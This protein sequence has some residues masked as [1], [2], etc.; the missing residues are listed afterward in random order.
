MSGPEGVCSRGCLVLGGSGPGGL[1]P[2]GVWSRGCTWSQGVYLVSGGCLVLGGVWFQG[3]SAPGGVSGPIGC[4]WSQGVYLVLGGI[5]GSRG[6]SAL[7]TH[8]VLGGVPGQA[9]LPC[10]QNDKQV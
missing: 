8:L 5:P 2:G 9:L 7:G 10:E 1:V 6:M 3:V 4:T